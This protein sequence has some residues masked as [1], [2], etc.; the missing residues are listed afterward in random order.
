MTPPNNNEA[1]AAILADPRSKKGALLDI[2]HR[3]QEAYGYIPQ[4]AVEAIAGHFG[5]TPADIHGVVTF[6]AELRTTPPAKKLIGVCQG[7]ACHLRGS[8]K[9][10]EALEAGLKGADVEVKDAQCVGTCQLAPMIWLDEE[11]EEAVGNIALE[12]VPRIV[13]DIKPY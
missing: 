13:E 5:T 2:L 11:Q 1:L 8:Q 3:V 9:L 7:P 6:Y 10:K 4:E 12:D